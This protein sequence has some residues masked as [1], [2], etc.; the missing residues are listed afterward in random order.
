MILPAV[1]ACTAAVSAIDVGDTV[2]DVTLQNMQGESVAISQ[3]IGK[4][5]VV[6]N[7]ASW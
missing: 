3:F 1:L 4:K 6:F 7:W 2:P 5:L